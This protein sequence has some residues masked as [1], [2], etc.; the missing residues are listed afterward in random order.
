MGPGALPCRRQGGDLNSLLPP[1]TVF[2][3]CS[4][5]PMVA[6]LECSPTSK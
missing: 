1:G 6:S 4:L 2:W 3:P 5:P